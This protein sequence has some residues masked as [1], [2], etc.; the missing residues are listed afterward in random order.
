[1]YGSAS[2]GRTSQFS[3]DGCS[4][5]IQLQIVPE[6]KKRYPRK[7]EKNGFNISTFFVYTRQDLINAFNIPLNTK[8][9]K[10]TGCKAEVLSH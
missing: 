6:G 5:L 2:Q 10:S 1:M 7:K 9:I 3:K 8:A 4:C